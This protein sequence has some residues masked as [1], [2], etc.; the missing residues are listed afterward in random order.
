MP[1]ENKKSYCPL[2]SQIIIAKKRV[3]SAVY[4]DAGPVLAEPTPAWAFCEK[5]KCAWWD[6]DKEQCS[7]LTIAEMTK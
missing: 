3:N 1:E 6:K 2:V 4:G 5:D 7:V